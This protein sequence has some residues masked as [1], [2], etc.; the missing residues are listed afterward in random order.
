M[1]KSPNKA[2]VPSPSLRRNVIRL[3]N[4]HRLTA[5]DVVDLLSLA[6]HQL[7]YGVEPSAEELIQDWQ[8]SFDVEP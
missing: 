3:A 4:R 2:D 8:D 7:A 5:E 1:A 6:Q